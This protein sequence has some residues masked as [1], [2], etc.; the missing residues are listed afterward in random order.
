M[1]FN[2][3]SAM[4]KPNSQPDLSDSSIPNFKSL[5]ASTIVAPSKQTSG[6]QVV[7]FPHSLSSE[8][9]FLVVDSAS[10]ANNFSL[11]QVDV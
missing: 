8:V 1:G 5:N 11:L 9:Y 4:Y 6:S 10:G 7:V 3:A 2:N